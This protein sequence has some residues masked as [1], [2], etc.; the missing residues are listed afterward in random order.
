VNDASVEKFMEV[1]CCEQHTSYEGKLESPFEPT[2]IYGAIQAGGRKMHLGTMDQAR[3]L[4]TQ[5][6]NHKK[7]TCVRSSTKC[8]RQETSQ[9]QRRSVIVCLPKAQGNQTPVDYHPI[10]FLN[11]G[12]KMFARIY[13]KRL[14]PVLAHHLT[15][16]QFGGVFGNR[17]LTRWQTVRETIP[18]AE[19]RRIPLCVISLDFKNVCFRIA[20]NCLFQTLQGYGIALEIPF[21][22]VSRG[23][24]KVLH[25][26]F[27]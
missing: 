8:S 6:G 16:T 17:S 14:C 11:S 21:S 24:M 2:E 7:T 25:P 19:S 12:Y 18:Y 3:I 15:E 4:V 22:P 5:L 1:V 20:H 23:C 9:Q 13:A 27:K 26:Q 10:T